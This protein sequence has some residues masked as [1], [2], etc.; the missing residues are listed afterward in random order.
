M[1]K[2]E[3]LSD[4]RP[5]RVKVL[6][7]NRGVLHAETRSASSSDRCFHSQ[8]GRGSSL[9]LS[10]CIPLA[11]N[12]ILYRRGRSFGISRG[13]GR[14][15]INGL[16]SLAPHGSRLDVSSS[17]VSNIPYQQIY[18]PSLLL[19]MLRDPWS[20]ANNDRLDSET[21]RHISSSVSEVTRLRRLKI[22]QEFWK[23]LEDQNLLAFDGSHVLNYLLAI[24]ESMLSEFATFKIIIIYNNFPKL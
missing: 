12:S 3:C 24:P 5:V 15:R 7:Q 16:R 4:N 11:Q 21:R 22:V 9:C 19:D 23:W 18:G 8:L 20:V 1:S 14:P 2:N 6:K 17:E 10:T 13:R